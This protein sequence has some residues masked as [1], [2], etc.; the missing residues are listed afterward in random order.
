VNGLPSTAELWADP[1]LIYAVAIAAVVL[2]AITVW[3]FRR[4]KKDGRAAGTICLV[5]SIGLHA[6]LV[7]LVPYQQRDGG[8][9]SDIEPASQPDGSDVMLFSTF[10]PDLETDKASGQEA[11]PPNVP[12]PVAELNDLLTEPPAEPDV[13]PAPEPPKPNANEPAAEVAAPQTLAESAS[14]RQQQAT[15][16]LDEQLDQAFAELIEQQLEV[17]SDADQPAEVAV[18]EESPRSESP[19]ETI[20][21]ETDQRETDR[22]TA[23]SPK[24]VRDA[25]ENR[26]DVAAT[27]SQDAAAANVPGSETADFANRVGAAKQRA[28][29]ETGGDR[30]TEAAVKAALRFLADAQS[31]DGSWDPR[32]SGAGQ[33]RMPLGEMRAGAGTKCT[34]GLT[35]LAL[36][37]MMG[38]GHTHQ[39][40]D[41]AENVYRG[42]AFLIQSQHPDGSLSGPAT[43]YAASYCHSMAAL[44][45]CEAAVMTR[46]PSAVECARRAIAHTERMQHPVTGGWRYTRGDPGDLSQLGWQAMVLDGGRRAGIAVR[47]QSLAGVARFLRSVRAGR[48]GLACYR[49]GEAFSRTMTAEALATRL[50]I[51]ERVPPE[52]IAE[53]ER[54]L[55]ES[56]P[57]T[58]TDNYYYWYYATIA[59]HQLQDDAW[60][61]WNDALKTRLIA[62]QRPNGSWPTSTVWGGYGGT[63]YTTSMAA[64]CLESY[65]RHAV[66]DSAGQRVARERDAPPPR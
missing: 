1:R 32:A 14:D 65:Y 12:L 15:D 37:A 46:D 33:E 11:T 19:A 21:G 20:Q 18:S 54:Y 48:G 31:P 40:G 49:P 41:Y 63:I 44:A 61:K 5:L 30:R 10:D 13:E 35:G 57:G 27:T 43:I 45:M 47:P 39:R 64:L 7:Y 26:A 17:Q 2:L 50:L 58:G 6:A 28:L 56:P 25:A 36:L 3:L 23:E 38:A 29:A 55:L 42:L 59:L 22:A 53:A 24:T 4:A 34:T 62:T 60:R 8:G 66:R 52:E 9:M 51:G 16:S